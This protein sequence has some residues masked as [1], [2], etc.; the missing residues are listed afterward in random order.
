MTTPESRSPRK[1]RIDAPQSYECTVCR[2]QDIL[3][4]MLVRLEKVTEPSY[5]ESGFYLQFYQV[6]YF[7]GPLQWS[8]AG[9]HK[10]SEEECAD[11]LRKAGIEVVEGLIG[12]GY[13]G[14]LKVKL[15]NSEVK[16]VA[17]SEVDIIEMDTVTV[18]PWSMSPKSRDLPEQVL[19]CD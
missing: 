6:A 8:G 3:D 2:Y 11:L 12:P 10:G 4:R 19:D 7:E 14:L 18:T 16:I 1:V 15:P 17:A 5:V 13:Y 9:F